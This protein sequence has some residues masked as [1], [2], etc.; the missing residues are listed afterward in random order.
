MVANDAW[1]NNPAMMGHEFIQMGSMMSQVV[2]R[3]E[4]MLRRQ[5]YK[6]RVFNTVREDQLSKYY[7]EQIYPS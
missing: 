6:T 5:D 2:S 7:S 4:D 1:G 3:R